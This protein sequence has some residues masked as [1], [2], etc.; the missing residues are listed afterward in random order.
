MPNHTIKVF[1]VFLKDG[2]VTL[3]YIHH[4]EDHP[5][6]DSPGQPVAIIPGDQ[7][8]W[9]SMNGAP[10]R[11]D[12]GASSPFVSGLTVLPPNPPKPMT[13]FETVAVVPPAG[14]GSDPDFKYTVTVNG[15]PA[16]DPDFVV[17]LSGGGPKIKK[18]KKVKGKPSPKHKSKK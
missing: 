13:K 10:I 11:I 2:T 18:P 4:Q 16:D 6:E 3:Q 14:D 12:F 15:I 1:T 9:K 7:V 5:T 17:D 8:R